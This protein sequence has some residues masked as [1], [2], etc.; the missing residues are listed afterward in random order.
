M[1]G[2]RTV[3]SRLPRAPRYI[4]CAGRNGPDQ[5]EKEK[6]NKTG[7]HIG[8]GVEVPT[9]GTV[10]A[11]LERDSDEVDELGGDTQCPGRS[12]GEGKAETGRSEEEKSG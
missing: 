12:A 5:S 6:G 9:E 1:D 10:P 11:T 2:F 7:D 4:V 3:K 8:R